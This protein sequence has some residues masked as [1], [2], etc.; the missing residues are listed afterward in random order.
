MKIAMIDDDA[1]ML[2]GLKAHLNAALGN[3]AEILSFPSGE[4]FLEVWAP[5]A[6]D[7][8]ILDIFMGKLTGMDVAR[9]IRKTD[10]QVYLVFCTTSNEFASESYEVNAS[11]YLR[12]PIGQDQVKAMLDRIDLAQIERLRTVRLPDGTCVVLHDILYVDCAAH[13]ITLHCKSGKSINIR[14]NFS[15]IEELLCAYSYFFCPSKGLIV[16]FREVAAKNTDSF[17][18][19]DGSRI[20]ISRRKAKEV[21][22][23]YSSFLFAAIRKGGE[24]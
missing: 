7:L 12:K 6:F 18:L 21:M 4:A 8:I 10:R 11:Y 19:T 5:S 1:Q 15:E 24:D 20:P 22:E 17:T 3:S 16:N 14:A 2:A 9:E 23:A 13:C